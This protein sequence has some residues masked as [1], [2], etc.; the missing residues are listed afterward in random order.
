MFEITVFIV[1]LW[2]LGAFLARAIVPLLS[3]ILFPFFLLGYGIW[4]FLFW[5]WRSKDAHR[6]PR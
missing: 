3:I 1:L 2:L 5:A 6:V 4:K